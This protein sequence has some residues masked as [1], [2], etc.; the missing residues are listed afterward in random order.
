MIT[1]QTLVS[2]EVYV[3]L[4]YA[5]C[6]FI[7]GLGEVLRIGDTYVDDFSTA[8]GLRS[9]SCLPRLAMDEVNVC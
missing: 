3:L 4:V 8:S 2:G 6:E 5:L 1:N 7:D 9:L